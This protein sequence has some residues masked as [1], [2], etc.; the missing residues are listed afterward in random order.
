MEVRSRPVQAAVIALVAALLGAVGPIGAQTTVLGEVQAYPAGLVA[1]GGV[2]WPMGGTQLGI[3]A[4]YNLTDRRDWGEHEQEDG[5]GAGAGVT[6]MWDMDARPGGFFLAAAL[7]VWRLSIDWEDPGRSGTSE[8]TV[9]QPTARVGYGVLW[10]PREV[11]LSL[12]GGWEINTRLTGEAVGE[13][14]IGLIGAAL[15]WGGR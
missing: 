10:G 4:G 7:D 12:S 8:V 13:G 14:P 5:G 6:L 11:R 2:E 1:T 9:F 15:A 3:R